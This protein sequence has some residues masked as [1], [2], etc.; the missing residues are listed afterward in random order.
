M[1]NLLNLFKVKSKHSMTSFRCIYCW[2]WPQS[3]YQSSVS[4]FNFKEAFVNSVRKTSHDVLK[5][6]KARYLCRNKSCKA[7]FIQRFIIVP[8]WN[9]LGISDNTSTLNL[10]YESQVYY[11]FVTLF[12]L[13]CHRYFTEFFFCCI[14]PKTYLNHWNSETNW[15]VWSRLFSI[16]S[17]W[18]I[19][20]AETEDTASDRH[21]FF[22]PQIKKQPTLPGHKEKI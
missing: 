2:P 16:C 9:W 19:P 7:Y 22:S 17:L 14:K 8:N 3:A 21:L 18:Y 13:L 12:D 5:K 20:K 6:Q 1:I 10:L 15:H 11:H 4:T